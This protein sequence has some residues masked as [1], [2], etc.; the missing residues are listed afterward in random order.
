MQQIHENHN[1]LF[2]RLSMIVGRKLI[3]DE[4][5]AG[6]KMIYCSAHTQ[7]HFIVLPKCCLSGQSSVL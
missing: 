4:S 6:K 7:S 1:K 2:I 3:K 5:P